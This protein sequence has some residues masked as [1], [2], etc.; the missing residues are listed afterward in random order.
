MPEFISWGIPR[1][2]KIIPQESQHGDGQPKE[3]SVLH[4]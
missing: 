2:L 4:W 3:A 1:G